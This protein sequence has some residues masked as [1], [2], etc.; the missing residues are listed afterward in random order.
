MV[1]A[2]T[3][4]QLQEILDADG[5]RLPPAIVTALDDVSAP[6]SSYPD[7]RAQH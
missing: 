3:A 7:Q 2:R 4:L 5:V 6:H 1:G